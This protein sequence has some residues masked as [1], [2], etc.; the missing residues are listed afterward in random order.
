MP[1]DEDKDEDEHDIEM[2]MKMQM[3][4][5]MKMKLEIEMERE[6]KT[7]MHKKMKVKL[8][9]KMIQTLQQHDTTTKYWQQQTQTE[10]ITFDKLSHLQHKMCN[11][12]QNNKQHIEQRTTRLTY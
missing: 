3:K 10:H 12:E 1:K 5:M 4:I 9:M 11:N 8:K 2:S 6:V 7:R